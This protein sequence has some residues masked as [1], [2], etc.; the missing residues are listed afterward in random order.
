[1]DLEERRARHDEDK[2]RHA[3]TVQ[4]IPDEWAL[5]SGVIHRTDGHSSDWSAGMLKKEPPPT[6]AEVAQMIADAQATQPKALT[7]AELSQYQFLTP[8]AAATV[9]DLVDATLSKEFADGIAK[10]RDEHDLRIRA[11]LAEIEKLQRGIGG[12]HGGEVIDLPPV[13]RSR[14]G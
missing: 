8:E 6:K 13:L 10:L 11:L 5:P 7:L 1:M 14:H 3:E 12:A 9:I 4:R 2:A